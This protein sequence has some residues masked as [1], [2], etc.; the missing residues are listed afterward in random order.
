MPEYTLE[1]IFQTEALK[2][3][4]INSIQLRNLLRMERNKCFDQ[5][6]V[7]ELVEE[8]GSNGFVNYEQFCQLWMYL[9][10]LREPFEYYARD[11][12]LSEKK[13]AKFLVNQLDSYIHKTTIKSMVHFYRGNLTFDVCVHALK[14][15]AGLQPKYCLQRNYITFDEYRQLL[16]RV[17]PTAP[18]E[19][20]PPSY[21]EVM[22]W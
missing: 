7:N 21:D 13:F 15:L 1:K 14:Q 16:H 5:M 19:D 10:V 4:R 11:G 2:S 18:C 3:E 20:N 17:K 6:L 12:V 9:R 22:S 8:F